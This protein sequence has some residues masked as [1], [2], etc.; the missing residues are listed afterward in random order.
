MDNRT[1]IAVVLSFLIIVGYQFLFP[2]QQPN[3]P[4]QKP[5]L[6]KKIDAAPP[7]APAK[8]VAETL[9]ADE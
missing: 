7:A 2:A 8:P 6:E 3:T 9:A 4:E 1:V 5:A